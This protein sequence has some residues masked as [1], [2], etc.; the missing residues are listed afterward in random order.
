MQEKK[1]R[2]IDE[3][4]KWAERVQKEYGKDKLGTK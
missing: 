4:K 2:E 1:E 3:K